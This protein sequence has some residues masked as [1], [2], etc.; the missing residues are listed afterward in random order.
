[1]AEPASTSGYKQMIRRLLTRASLD[2]RRLR[3]VPFGVR[4]EDD[5]T[6]YLDGRSLGVAFDVGAHEGETALMLLQTFPGVTVHSFEPMPEN[7][8]ALTHAVAGQAV[9]AVHAAASD[10]SG[11]VEMAR[12]DTSFRGSIHGEGPTI[13]VPAIAIAD[14]ARD[15]HLD[16]VDLL[17]IDTEGHEEAVLRGAGSLLDEGAIEFVLC[18]CDFTRRPDEPHGDF[19]TI[20]DLLEPLGYRVV[21]FYTAGVD[22]LGWLWG[23]VLFRY[24]PGDRDNA[25]ASRSP[26]SRRPTR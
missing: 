15:R 8:S 22:N 19:R 7:H 5:I 18:E 10:R 21:A 25:W 13:T 24:A 2:V 1:M 26:H 3:N 20:F 23:D 12:G 17:K 11:S 4:W 6:Y 16:R 14:Y 9:T